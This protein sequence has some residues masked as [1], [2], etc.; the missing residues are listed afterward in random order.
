[1]VKTA[2]KSV[3]NIVQVD[4]EIAILSMDIVDQVVIQGGLAHF[5]TEVNLID[6]LIIY[7]RRFIQSICLFLNMN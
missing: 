1:M 4:T 6:Y 5:V 7:H 3:V 2:W